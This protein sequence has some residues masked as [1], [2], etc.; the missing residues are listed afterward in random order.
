MQT[1][2]FKIVWWIFRLAFRILGWIVRLVPIGW[3]RRGTTAAV[4][5]NRRDRRVVFVGDVLANFAALVYATVYRIPNGSY[6]VRSRDGRI[7]ST[8]SRKGEPR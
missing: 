7:E 4:W 8:A 3:C 5:R 2:M 6:Y 1:E